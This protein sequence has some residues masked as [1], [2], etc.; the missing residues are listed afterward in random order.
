MEQ[1][2]LYGNNGTGSVLQSIRPASEELDRENY[3]HFDDAGVRRVA[4]NPVST[5]SID[6]DTGAYS[7]VR[8]M[9]NAG[10]LPARDAVRVE[11]MINYFSYDYPTPKT[12]SPP[13]AV[14]TEIGPTPWNTNSHLLHIGIRGF[15]AAKE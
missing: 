3:A 14:F 4:E 6:V 9:L 12:D 7:N 1:A 10:R 11:E 5:F 13:F 8:R 2:A 15:D